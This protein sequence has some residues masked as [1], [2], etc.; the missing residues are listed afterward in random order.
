MVQV[1]FAYSALLPRRKKECRKPRP[2]P[3][4]TIP[5]EDSD[6]EEDEVFDTHL[7][8]SRRLRVITVPFSI[9]KS[10]ADMYR[11][12]D[13]DATA[14]ILANKVSLSLPID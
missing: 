3:G 1:A 4:Q 6:E 5:D 7:T 2:I 9:A 14:A 10:E 11:S 8:L 13:A 12:C